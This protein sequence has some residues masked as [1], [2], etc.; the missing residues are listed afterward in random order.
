MS[1]PEKIVLRLE[2]DREDERIAGRLSTPSGAA[3]AFVGWI[4]LAAA[5]EQAMAPTGT[6]T[7]DDPQKAGDD[8]S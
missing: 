3:V 1:P 6:G 7:P 4:G 5:I 8:F 2:I